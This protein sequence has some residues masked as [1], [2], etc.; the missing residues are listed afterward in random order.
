MHHT[1]LI[2]AVVALALAPTVAFMKTKG[3]IRL[4]Q[5]AILLIVVVVVVIDL[6]T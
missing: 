2:L 4:I 6:T 1:A 3:A 5:L